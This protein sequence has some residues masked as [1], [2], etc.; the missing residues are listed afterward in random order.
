M[1]RTTTGQISLCAVVPEVRAMK[2]TTHPF[3]AQKLITSGAIHP[4]SHICIPDMQKE[5][6][7]T[8]LMHFKTSTMPEEGRSKHKIKVWG[9]NLKIFFWYLS[10]S[11]NHITIYIYKCK[12]QNNVPHQQYLIAMTWTT[13]ARE[14]SPVD[15][16]QGSI[17]LCYQ[18]W[19]SLTCMNCLKR[20]SYLND[21]LALH[22]T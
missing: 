7:I 21:P 5:W 1:S 15:I 20:I 12:K 22:R 11:T 16:L 3:I 6:T 10:P 2:Q 14:N 18:R 4:L 13:V 8:Y 19:Q 9:V 17:K